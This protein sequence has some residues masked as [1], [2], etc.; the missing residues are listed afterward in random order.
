MSP[1]HA[2]NRTRSSHPRQ[3][4]ACR[5]ALALLLGITA[6]PVTAAT[7]STT[8]T[9]VAFGA[10][11]VFAAGAVNTTGTLKVTCSLDPLESGPVTAAFT[12]SLSTGSS[13]SFVQRQMVSG[14]N[15]LVYNLYTANTHSVVW[16]DGS[17]A[18]ATVSGSIKLT[19]GTPSRSENKTVYGQV[20]ALQDVAV[21]PLYSD[22]IVV[23]TSY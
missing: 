2:F 15:L 12:L 22:T 20:S 8:T 14:T 19:N 13:N 6:A 9:G 1:L 21:S 16:G 4:S 7:C 5:L 3:A 17:G 23:T 18:T 11:N 10:Y